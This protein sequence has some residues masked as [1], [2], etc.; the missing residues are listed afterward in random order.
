MTR[1]VKSFL[2]LIIARVYKRV[3]PEKKPS[4]HIEEKKNNRWKVVTRY[5]K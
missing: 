1:C 3:F 5:K 2:V 4:H